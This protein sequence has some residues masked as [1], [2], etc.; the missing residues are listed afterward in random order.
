MTGHGHGVGANESPVVKFLI[1]GTV[2]WTF[3]LII[4]HYL[5][6][7]KI[8]KQTS[9]LSYA[10]LTRN[11]VKTKGLVGVLDGYFPWGSIQWCVCSRVDSSSA[12]AH[13]LSESPR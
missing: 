9:E 13:A 8:S 11:M 7:L 3:E 2:A 4:G 1:S 10:Q 12:P 5:E 6:F